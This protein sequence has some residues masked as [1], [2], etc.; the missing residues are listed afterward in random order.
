[1]LY[2]SGTTGRP[3]GVFVPPESTDIAY[4][5]SLLK[6]LHAAVR[7]GRRTRSTCRPGRCTTPRRCALRWR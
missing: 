3:K 5:N 6:V 4:V 1:M 7:D 2:S